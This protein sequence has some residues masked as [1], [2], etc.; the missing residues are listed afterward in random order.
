MGMCRKVLTRQ[1]SAAPIG[2]RS[3]EAKSSQRL[4]GGPLS[5]HPTG[6]DQDSA[7]PAMTKGVKLSSKARNLRGM[8]P[9]LRIRQKGGAH[10]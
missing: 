2:D 10:D 6:T 7:K 8:N 4:T 9:E 3:V 1:P 5:W